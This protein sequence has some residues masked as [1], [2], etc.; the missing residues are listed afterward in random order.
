MATATRKLFCNWLK[1][2]LQVSDVSGEIFVLPAFNKYEVV[3]IELV[4]VEPDVATRGIPRFSRVDISNLSLAIAL[5]DT[6]D[7]ATP[8]AYQNS[9]TKDESTNKFTGDLSLA[10]AALNSWLGSS[11]SKDAYFEIEVQEGSNVS[12]IFQ[13]TVTVKNSVAQVGATVPSPVD[14]YF[15]K[16]QVEAQFLRHFNGAGIQVAILSPSG[17]YQRIFG[18]DDGGN[19]ID[20]ILPYP[21]S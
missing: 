17:N 15:T 1:K 18:V 9:F 11:D 10:T 13:A 14:E 3:P 5:N 4:I 7:D 12:K 6:Y 20:Q 16:A 19:A 2:T 21:P 8:L